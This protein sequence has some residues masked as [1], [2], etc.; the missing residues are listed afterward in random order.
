MM[1]VFA[2]ALVTTVLVG[3]ATQQGSA[4][5]TAAPAP[6]AAPAAAAP[7]APK[8]EYGTFGFDTAGMDKSIAPGDDFYE[9][10]NGTWAKNTPIP[11]DKSNYGM[12]NVLDDLSQRADAADH[13]RAGEGSEQQDR[14]RLRQLHGRGGDRGKGAHT[15]RAVAGAGSWPQVEGGPRS[16]STR[17]RAG[18]GSA[19]PSAALSVRTTR[20]PISTFCN[21]F[22][23]GLG[24]A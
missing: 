22:Q 4:P 7:A 10:A 3:C 8:P 15:V 14:Q 24:H 21:V 1:R 20:P 12:F 9:F 2:F 19:L 6:G 16:R 18:F 13:R 11:A 5:L 17:K 23:G